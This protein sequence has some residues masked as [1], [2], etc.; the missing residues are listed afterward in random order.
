MKIVFLG[1]PDFALPS[2]KAL[3][4]SPHEI[5]AVITNPDRLGNRQKLTPPPVKV[6][7]ESV[8]LKV[9]Q[10]S[11]IRKEGVDELKRLAPDLMVTAAFGQILSQ[12]ILD[13]PKY[14]VINVHGSLLPK[15]RGASPIQQAILD[16]ES[17]TGVTI[18]KTALE[19]DSGDI[20]MSKSVDIGENE[21][22]GELFIRL[23]ELGAKAL[24][25]AIE[26]IDTG[27]AV[28]IAQDHSKATFCA[29][30]KKESGI[31]DFCKTS[32]ELVNFV[33]GL[34]PWPTA[35]TYLDGKML[36]IWKATPHD[37]S[38]NHKCGEVVDNANKIIVQVKDGT[39]ELG[40]IQLEGSKR[41]SAA[42]FLRGR[43]IQKRTVLGK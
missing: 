18:M 5:A 36:K 42:D 2:I 21:T 14:G 27:K 9:L 31:I 26:L 13:I 39:I 19:V 23:S 11:K 41:M 24:I 35:Y 3:N 33:R 12:E 17:V 30:L 40:E 16:G 25:E 8:G 7:A 22:A 10:Y 6:F 37:N 1:T 15:Y 32:K 20:I 38:I 43:A 4:D 28:Y 29:M 34:N